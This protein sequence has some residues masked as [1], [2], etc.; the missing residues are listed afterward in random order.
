[1]RTR[2]RE[3]WKRSYGSILRKEAGGMKKD[4]GR[5]GVQQDFYVFGAKRWSD[6]FLPI[7][8]RLG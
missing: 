1:M 2:D 8:H 7:H 3:M 5:K 6:R 4:D